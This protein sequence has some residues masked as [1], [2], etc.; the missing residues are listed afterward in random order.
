MCIFSSGMKQMQN[1]KTIKV[2]KILVSYFNRHLNSFI[3]NYNEVKTITVDHSGGLN[4]IYVSHKHHYFP[5]TE[6]LNQIRQKIFVTSNAIEEATPE[7]AEVILNRLFKVYEIALN[8]GD[9]KLEKELML[10]L[11]QMFLDLDNDLGI[12]RFEERI[13]KIHLKNLGFEREKYVLKE[14]KTNKSGLNKLKLLYWAVFNPK[15][16]EQVEKKEQ[17]KKESFEQAEA[18]KKEELDKREIASQKKFE[19][20]HLE[21]I[22]KFKNQ[23]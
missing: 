1:E 17:Q 14:W 13:N 12:K 19:K 2:F 22:W 5:L 20:E 4:D 7:L 18:K 6:E 21:I 3:G 10:P 11:R 16:R 15:K 9:N 8:G 23:S